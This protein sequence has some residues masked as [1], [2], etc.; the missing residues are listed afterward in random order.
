MNFELKITGELPLA[1]FT[2]LIAHL[3]GASVASP[4]TETAKLHKRNLPR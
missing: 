2:K 1:D 4:S 3:Q